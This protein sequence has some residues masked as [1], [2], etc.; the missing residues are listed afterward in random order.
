MTGR[1]PVRALLPH[2][3]AVEWLGGAPDGV[4]I[5]TFSGRGELPAGAAEVEFWVPAIH[6]GGEALDVLDRLPALRVV[7]TLTAGVEALV[8]RIPAGVTLCDARGVHDSSTAEWVLA[9]LLAHYRE[10]PRFVLAQH[11]GRWDAGA[12]D[13]LADKTVLIVGY[14]SIGAAIEA[15]LQPFGVELLRVARRSRPEA[16]VA[17]VA[18]LPELL[19]RADAVVVILP[20][21]AA[22]RGLVD[23]DFLARMRTGALLVNAGRGPSVVTDALLAELTSGRLRAALDVTD[24]EPLPVGHPL[25]SAPGLLLTPHVAG[26][27]G[28]VLPRGYRLVRA[29]LE[30]YVASE[31][32]ANVVTEGY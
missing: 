25:W 15:R 21:T 8:D 27:V 29:Q 13:E 2:R 16:G 22:T 17:D 5:D 14:G 32:L 11:A 7:Q 1:G 3:D 26:A 30:R 10:L 12:T 31:P 9:V 20:L 6:A 23:A 24:P 4:V 18:A 28:G 19:P